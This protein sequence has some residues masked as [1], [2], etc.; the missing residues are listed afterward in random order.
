M[1]LLVRPLSPWID[2]RLMAWDGIQSLLL[3]EPDQRVCFLQFPPPLHD[4]S[5]R[6][7][8]LTWIPMWDHAAFHYQEPRWWQALPRAWRIVSFCDEVTRLARSTER[9]VFP[10]QFWREPGDVDPVSWKGPRVLFYWNRLGLVGPGFL[11]R[12]CRALR[13]DRLIFRSEMDPNIPIERYYRLPV[14]LGSTVVEELP[15]SKDKTEYLSR[16]NAANFLLAPRPIEGV[17]LIAV[18]ALARGCAVLA[19]DLPT[20]NEYIRR[21]DNGYLFEPFAVPKW[22]HTRKRIVKRRNSLRM[23]SAAT[24]WGQGRDYFLSESQDWRTLDRM[25][26]AALG[27]QARGDSEKGAQAWRRALPALARF[28]KGEDAE[29]AKLDESVKTSSFKVAA[30]TLQSTSTPLVSICLPHLNSMPFTRE[31]LDS[32]LSQTWPHWECIVVDSGSSDGS[33]E[34]I[35]EAMQRDSR[36]RLFS[37]PRHGIYHAFNEVIRHAEGDFI[38]IATADDTLHPNGLERMVHG[39]L[40]HPDCGACHTPLILLNERSERILGQYEKFAHVRYLGLWMDIPHIRRHPHDAVLASLIPSVY[41]SVTQMLYRRSAVDRTG[42]F[43]TEFGSAGDIAWHMR[44]A[45]FTDV[46]HLPEAVGTWRLHPLQ[47]T[48]PDDPVALARRLYA[49]VRWNTD[50]LF[51]TNPN[52]RLQFDPSKLGFSHRLDA[53]RMAVNAAPAYRRRVRALLRAVSD[54]PGVLRYLYH[55]RWGSDLSF[56]YNNVSMARTFMAQHGLNCLI[57]PVDS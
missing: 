22:S 9:C 51:A 29:S 47:A 15:F 25:D 30:R 10:I 41:V 31:R 7:R 27:V 37:Q 16:V 20:A 14:R 18:D 43:P 4:L 42:P 3:P 8:P 24:W 35:R 1:E 6:E 32:I 12:L 36:I 44:L 46:L 28:L 39:L 54:D 56:Q 50:H 40:R 5:W 2:I 53:L 55:G 57:K 34:L 52:L 17:G 13:I 48:Q 23:A 11:K 19:V 33:L 38:Y 26:W 45:A 49:M 21:A